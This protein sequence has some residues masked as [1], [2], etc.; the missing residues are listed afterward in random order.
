MGLPRPLFEFSSLQAQDVELHWMNFWINSERPLP[1]KSHKSPIQTFKAQ[2]AK[3][4]DK[5]ILRA[6]GTATPPQVSFFYCQFFK[7]D[8]PW[9]HPSATMSS[10]SPCISNTIMLTSINSI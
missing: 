2:N 8:N 9:P 10:F 4:G 7:S 6:F 5:K 1:Q 3:L